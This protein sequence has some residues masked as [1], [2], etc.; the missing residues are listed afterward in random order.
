MRKID[1]STWDRKEIFDFFS[2]ISDPFYMV[3]FV[4]DVT[5]LKAYTKRMDCSFYYSLIYLCN[6]A[7]S[8]IENFMYTCI[9][10]DIYVLDDR[11][12]SFTDRNK[13]SDLFKIITIPMYEDLREFVNR[14][15]EANKQQD[16]FID[17]S[18]EANNLAYYSCLPT[19]RLTALSNE[20]DLMNPLLKDDNIPRIC[21]GKYTENS[22]RLEL[23]ISLEVNHRFIDGVH[24]E[25]FAS[26]LEESIKELKNY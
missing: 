19:L 12:P 21:W 11:M 7:L 24:I 20:F 18:L 13:N 17:M 25:K 5:E 10:D 6:K 8:S 4:M 14:A 22:G 26:I 9:D 16:S 23:T 15:N 1:K 2:N 3:S